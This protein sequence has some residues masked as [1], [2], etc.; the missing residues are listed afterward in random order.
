MGY[1]FK[2]FTGQHGR[3]HYGSYIRIQKSGRIYVSQMARDRLGK[4]IDV[5][6]D[7]TD[8]LIGLKDGDTFKIYGSGSFWSASLVDAIL[9]RR[10]TVINLSWRDD[11]DML[12]GRWIEEESND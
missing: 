6:L 7:H 2:K 10:G 3:R 8:K 12:V 11:V 9:A 5:F 4:T 1:K